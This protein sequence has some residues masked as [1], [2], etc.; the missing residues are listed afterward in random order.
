MESSEAFCWGRRGV[1]LRCATPFLCGGYLLE[2]RLELTLGAS[3]IEMIA[4][5]GRQAVEP[6]GNYLKSI[7][8]TD[9][10]QCPPRPPNHWE[11]P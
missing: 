8:R 11:L 10:R 4:I 9:G 2:E 3:K 5:D 1:L 7:S 6:K